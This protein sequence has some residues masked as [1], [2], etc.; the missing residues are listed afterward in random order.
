M[1]DLAYSERAENG[2]T[3]LPLWL[4]WGSSQFQRGC[5]PLHCRKH[6]RVGVAFTVA[7]GFEESSMICWENLDRGGRPAD[8][9]A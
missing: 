5:L 7:P 3:S 2:G 8:C 1:T 4:G 9:P 6:V